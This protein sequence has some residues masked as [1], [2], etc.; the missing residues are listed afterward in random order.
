MKMRPIPTELVMDVRFWQSLK[1]HLI[2]VPDDPN[3]QLAFLFASPSITARRGRL[4]VHDAWFISADDLDRQSP[5]GISP[6]A[7]I[8]FQAI[9]R[10]SREG[11][12]LI[13]THSHPFSAGPGTSF[14]G[15]D[16]NN[17]QQKFP[18]VGRLL[19]A[20]SFHATMVVGQDSLD[21]HIFDPDVK[22][23]LPLSAVVTVGVEPH[24][25]QLIYT[26]MPTTSST[27]SLVH[28][29]GDA[30]S[31]PLPE[32]FLRHE[33]VFGHVGQE[34]LAQ[35]SVAVVG[36]G[37]LGSFVALELAHLGIGRLVLIDPDRVET[38]NL[39]RL[40]GAHESD[41]G[42]LK[43]ETLARVITAIR[44]E[45]TVDTIAA[46]VVDE[47]ALDA[48]KGIDVIAGCVDNHGARMVL[49][50]LAIRYLL[51]LV[52]AGTGI[53]PLQSDRQLVAGGQ[54]QVVVPGCGCLECRGFIDMKRA[55]FDLASPEQRAE[56]LAHG[57]GIEEPAPSV[58]FLNGV[59]ASAQVAEIVFLLTNSGNPD[60]GGTPSYTIYDALARSMTPMRVS[61]Q[62]TCITCGNDGVLAVGD[63]AP[64]VAKSDRKPGSIPMLP[65]ITNITDISDIPTVRLSLSDSHDTPVDDA[66]PSTVTSAA[67]HDSGNGGDDG[68]NGDNS[69]DA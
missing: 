40:L 45:M 54:V 56:S 48:L 67:P 65:T 6:K 64:I 38:T 20:S 18:T 66:S 35:S 31:A 37:G 28:Q 41:V 4:L 57:Y 43:V 60:R 5:A 49:N 12:S 33:A 8:V 14:S 42:Q 52:D 22:E 51:P 30:V 21:A 16:W 13:E 39:N 47:A 53:K 11:W 44:S 19:S 29:A 25:R 58:I 50:Q 3:E 69:R 26:R 62:A 7:E 63:L 1:Q 9:D 36:V 23:I 34:R 2:R 17:D 24:S 10:C 68:D 32:R 59:A 61:A 55:A 15:V 46:N 27:R